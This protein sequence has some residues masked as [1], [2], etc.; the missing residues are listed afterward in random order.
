[1]SRGLLVLE[2]AVVTAMIGDANY[3][4]AFPFLAKA[5]EERSADAAGCRTCGRKRAAARKREVDR[6]N[7]VK[8]AIAGM[9]SS[10][11]L[12]LKRMLD[13]ERLRVIYVSTAGVRQS[14]TF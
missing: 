5:A 6:L 4:A 7:R 11:K 8:Q 12:E 10:R 2:D 14:L 13:S 1:M 3:R 9:P